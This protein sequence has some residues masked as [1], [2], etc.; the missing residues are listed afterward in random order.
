L[1]LKGSRDWRDVV[2][3]REN[4]EDESLLGCAA[5]A[6]ADVVAASPRSGLPSEDIEVALTFLPVTEDPVGV[7]PWTPMIVPRTEP[8]QRPKPV[9]DLITWDNYR[10][11]LDD[12][13]QRPRW[14]H[15]VCRTTEDPERCDDGA[16]TFAA[17][18]ARCHGMR[19]VQLRKGPSLVGLIGRTRT[20]LSGESIVADEAYVTRAIR[21]HASV[22][23]Y[24]PG[25]E[26]TA[27]RVLATRSGS[28]AWLDHLIHQEQSS[29]VFRGLSFDDAQDLFD[30]VQALTSFIPALSPE[31]GVRELGR[32]EFELRD[33]KDPQAGTLLQKQLD[34]RLDSIRD[35]FVAELAKESRVRGSKVHGGTF[36]FNLYRLWDFQMA[37]GQ[38]FGNPVILG[39]V[40]DGVAD[41][42][43]NAIAISPSQRDAIHAGEVRVTLHD[44]GGDH[45]TAL[46]RRQ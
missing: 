21:D 22:D 46:L 35:C 3:K 38:Y 26:G 34:W 31:T 41:A 32:V 5:D 36:R 25:W 42:V 15:H 7:G 20:F 24:V 44:N 23:E 13:L 11:V 14:M 28:V 9:S 45:P 12:L 39:C 2:A 1:R 29:W 30:D 4:I 8:Y 43:E 6:M 37:R 40:I 19:G 16:V 17:Q 33:I 18:C 10:A 27:E